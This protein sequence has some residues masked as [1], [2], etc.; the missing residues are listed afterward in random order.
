MEKLPILDYNY[1]ELMGSGCGSVDRVVAAQL[2][3]WS[4]ALLEVR[5]SNP[6]IS[7]IN[8]T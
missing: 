3:E 8:R 2:T 1:F 6:V 4:L 7:E 5:G